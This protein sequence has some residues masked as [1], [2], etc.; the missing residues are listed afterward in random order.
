[1]E[2]RATQPSPLP[3]TSSTDNASLI[4]LQDVVFGDVRSSAIIYEEKEKDG[5]SV[6]TAL[7]DSQRWEDDWFWEEYAHPLVEKEDAQSVFEE[8]LR[9]PESAPHDK[10]CSSCICSLCLVSTRGCIITPCRHRVWC[11]Q[12][13]KQLRSCYVCKRPIKNIF[14]FIPLRLFVCFA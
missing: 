6:E 4:S 2:R 7:E 14:R 5:L 8:E 10:E 11:Y 1:M 3:P 9:F 12:C 13:T